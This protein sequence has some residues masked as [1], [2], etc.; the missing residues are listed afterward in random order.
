M[1]LK[2][3]D[4]L[5]PRCL[6]LFSRHIEI[7]YFDKWDW[8]RLRCLS[9]LSSSTSTHIQ[10]WS[11]ARPQRRFKPKLLRSLDLPIRVAK[12]GP[13]FNTRSK[14]RQLSFRLYAVDDSS[15]MYRPGN[16]PIGQQP[17]WAATF[18]RIQARP[19]LILTSLYEVRPQGIAFDV[20]QHSQI[21]FVILNRERLKPPLPDM[22]ASL[23]MSMIPPHMSGQ[24][25]LHP[26]TQITISS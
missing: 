22:S 24:Q 13:P 16:R 1:Y 18:G 19:F 6:S 5:R 26:A 11:P 3:G 14:C 12:R 9:H 7:G 17:L 21:M 4:R 15:P 10:P 2:K 23:V 8:L 25:P 20:T